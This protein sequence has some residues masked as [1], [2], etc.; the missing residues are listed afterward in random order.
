MVWD[1]AIFM[2]VFNFLIFDFPD[3]Y[4]AL[5]SPNALPFARLL[6]GFITLRNVDVLHSSSLR[7]LQTTHM[8]RVNP[9]KIGLFLESADDIHCDRVG[10]SWSVTLTLFPLIMG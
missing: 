6:R 4:C 1:R 5:P 9:P 10:E 2:V 7:S 3:P 8:R